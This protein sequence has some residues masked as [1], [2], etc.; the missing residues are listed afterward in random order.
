MIKCKSKKIKDIRKLEILVNKILNSEEVTHG[1][2]RTLRLLL[3]EAALYEN[4]L[5]GLEKIRKRGCEF[6]SEY[7]Q[8]GGGR[9]TLR[10][11]LNIDIVPPADILFDVREGLPLET[12]SAR[13]IFAEHFLEHLDYP[14]SAKKFIS[15]CFRVLKDEG[16]L[17]LGVPNS[18][19]VILAYTRKDKNYWKKMLSTWYS[20]RNCLEHF[21]TYIDLVNYHFR[22][23]D[24]D[25][26]YN[27][28]FWAYDLEKLKSMAK[29][30]GFKKI[31]KWKFDP[32]IA[33]PKRRWGSIYIEAIK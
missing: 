23:Q 16:K 28:H 14:T 18:R 5:R 29:T 3:K 17:I 31:K 12:N 9:H 32:R 1:L 2:A 27:P 13:L 4:H 26:K 21:N 6:K 22:D 8:V 33:N 7:I 11:F 19:Q 15:E 20:K 10:G 30:A 25:P 24:D